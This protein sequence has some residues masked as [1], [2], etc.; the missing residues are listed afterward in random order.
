MH[1]INAKMQEKLQQR[2][3]KMVEKLVADGEQLTFARN[4]VREKF[5]FGNKT[6]VDLTMHLSPRAGKERTCNA[7]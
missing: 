1:G 5:G 3:V 2:A 6:I 7:E 4:K